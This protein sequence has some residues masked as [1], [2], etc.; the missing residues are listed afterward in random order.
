MAVLEHFCFEAS[1]ITTSSRIDQQSCAVR[2]TP[3]ICDMVPQIAFGRV[4]ALHQNGR[5]AGG[6]H[7][8][9]AAF[10]AGELGNCLCC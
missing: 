6:R 1:K 4:F 3:D 9:G 8:L 2:A 5:L 10:D 7:I